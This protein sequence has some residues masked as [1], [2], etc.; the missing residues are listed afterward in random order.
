MKNNM[1]K[2]SFRL[3]VLL[4]AL[5]LLSGCGEVPAETLPSSDVVSSSA[6]ESPEITET[7]ASSSPVSVESSAALPVSGRVDPDKPMVA[8]TYDDGP[9]GDNT[10]KIVDAMLKNGGRCTFFVVGSRL[11]TKSNARAM[12]Y[13]VEAD[14][15]IGTHTQN[16]PRMW[17][18]DADSLQKELEDSVSA[19]QNIADVEVRFFRPTGGNM[20]DFVSDCGYPLILWSVDTEDWKNRDKDM[21]VQNIKD[22]VC[23]GAIILMHDLYSCT[24]EAT[25]EILPWLVEQGYQLVTVSELFAARGVTPVNGDVWGRVRPQKKPVSATAEKK[26]TEK[27][28]PV[29]SP[30]TSPAV[31]SGKLTAPSPTVTVSPVKPPVSPASTVTAGTSASSIQTQ[32]EIA[33]PETTAFDPTRRT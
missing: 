20:P 7:P 2:V 16:H 31:S 26:T 27:Q 18:L 6:P 10:I 32:P 17:D 23:D 1:K 28:V 14:C 25:E 22:N 12:K 11:S 21:I 19:I 3:L 5:L 30:V 24:A 15:E 13:A 4:F 8:L 9:N 33:A 29:I